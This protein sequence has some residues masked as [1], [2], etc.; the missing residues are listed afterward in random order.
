MGFGLAL[1]CATPGDHDTSWEG[2]NNANG[3]FVAIECPVSAAVLITTTMSAEEN[4]LTHNSAKCTGLP[5]S[6]E[7]RPLYELNV[8]L[9]YVLWNLL[10][11]SPAAKK[12]SLGQISACR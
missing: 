6:I 8:G 4:P 7:Q 9:Y 12:I 10:D 2:Y 11:R 3:R 5:N 1:H